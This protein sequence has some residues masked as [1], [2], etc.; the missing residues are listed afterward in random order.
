MINKISFFKKYVLILFIIIGTVIYLYLWQK[1]YG[2]VQP[3]AH[4]GYLDLSDWNFGKNG[5]V[6]LDGEWEFYWNRLLTPNDLVEPKTSTLTGYI[7]VPSDWQGSI[8]NVRLSDKGAAT[9]RLKVHLGNGLAAAGIKTTSIRMSSR[10]FIDGTEVLSSGNPALYKK[11]GY[12]MANTPYS[13]T[14]YP[15]DRDIEI[16]VQVADFDYKKGGIVQS[17]YL[18][19]QK[20]IYMLSVRNNFL[21]GFLAACLFITGLYYFFVFLGRRKD[22]SILYYSLYAFTFSLFESLYGEKILLQM[23]ESLSDRYD[24]LVKIHNVLLH[25][26]IIFV[27]LFAKKIAEKAIP[28]WFIKSILILFGGYCVFFILFPL[29]TASEFQNIA[30]LLGMA[31]YVFI[32]IVFLSAIIKKQYGA[33]E[34]SELIRLVVAFT[35]VLLYFADG[36]LYLNNV[37]SDNYVGYMF[38]IV[39]IGTVFSLLSKQYNKSFNTLE[40]MNIRLLE[41]DKLKDAFLANTSHELRTPLNGIINITNSVMESSRGTLGAMQEKNLQIVISAARRLYNLINDILDISNLKNGEIRLYKRP[42]DLHSVVGMTLYVLSQ[43]KGDKEIEFINNIPEGIPPVQADAERLR[44]IFYNLIG[45]ALK[46]TQHGYIEVGAA[47]KN[48][49]AEIWV[50]DTGSGIPQ[51]KLEDIFKHF[52]QVDSTET[53]E[54]GGTGLGLSITK[55]LIELHGGSIWV[56]SEEGKGSRFLFTLPLSRESKADMH[57]ESIIRTL[58]KTDEISGLTSPEEKEKRTYSILAVDDDPASLTALFNIL[59]NEGYYVKAVTSGEE[60]LK[61]IERQSRYNLVILDVMMPRISGFEVLKKIRQRFQPMDIPV[62]ML[63]AKARP[64]DLQAGFEAGANDYL[65]KPF[66]ALELKARVRTLVQLKESVNGM[67]TTE[68][69]F[70]QAQI[71]PHFLYNSLSVIAALSTREPQRTKELLYDLADYLRGS[72]NFENFAGV[73]PI[74]SELATVR[75]YISIEKERFRGKLKVEYDIDETIDISVPML[76]I[77]PLVENAIRHGILKKPQGGMVRLGVKKSQKAIIISVQDDGIGIPPEK[78]SELFQEKNPKTGVGLRNI[79][80]RMILYYG[81]GLD[82]QS[83]VGQGTTVTMKIFNSNRGDEV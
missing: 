37:K 3:T 22:L 73:T 83:I 25:L 2:P 32:I 26:T 60:L 76:A 21:N 18:G 23:F 43:L 34:K 57:V 10:I 64:E 62:L 11:D 61:E 45:N 68:L 79:Q 14:F 58:N 35:C 55:T 40:T 78:L 28:K 36:T 46:F 56:R 53:R 72:F 30:L 5:N 1:N 38:M 8:G 44:Q 66:E 27:C 74:A 13:A 82:I 71:K 9:Y 7:K 80:R 17:I 47:I 16:I 81:Q 49:Y 67:V 70:L 65:S 50:T 48:D 39:F 69:S 4:Q 51:D 31:A 77:Q 15:K 19:N 29:S 12:V 42:V 54:A 33:L 41:L 52:F 6:R 63:T 24:I 75:A 20:N 59:D